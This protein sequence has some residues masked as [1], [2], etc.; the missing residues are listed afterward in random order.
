MAAMKGDFSEV[1]ISSLPEYIASQTIT[2]IKIPGLN[3]QRCV[4]ELSK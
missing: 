2:P 4:V 3:A 1:E